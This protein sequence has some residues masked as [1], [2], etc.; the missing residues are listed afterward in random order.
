MKR[1]TA[2]A[3]SGVI[4]SYSAIPNREWRIQRIQEGKPLHGFHQ[5]ADDRALVSA[6]V[7]TRHDGVTRIILLIEWSRHRHEYYC[8]VFPEDKSRPLAEFQTIQRVAAADSLAWTYKPTK[9]DGRN[10]ERKAYFKRHFGDTVI[11]I[12]IPSQA[13]EVP[14]FLDAVFALV[15]NRLSADDLSAREPEVRSAFPEGAAT[16]R[17]H[18]TKE[19]NRELVSLAKD[20][21]M[22]ANGRLACRVCDF[23]FGRVYGEVGK[24]FIEAH[25]TLPLSEL[26]GETETRPEDLALVCSNCHKMLH[27]RRP[28]L[29][30]EELKQLLAS[31]EATSRLDREAT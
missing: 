11:G 31:R 23:D 3:L 28:W 2:D 22:E 27:R 4:K 24:G 19:R 7:V 12:T 10:D 13:D 6:D 15:E 21:A 1:S 20:R 29:G 30:M 25:H 16:E 17:L 9:R 5:W 8:V 26:S 14:D 18:T